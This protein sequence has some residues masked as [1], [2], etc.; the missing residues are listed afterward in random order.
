MKL[1]IDTNVLIDFLSVRHPFYEPAAE[2][3]TRAE[4][5]EVRC[6]LSALSVVTAQ[7]VCCERCKMPL[8]LWK[9]NMACLCNFVDVVDVTKEDILYSCLSDWA[10][11]EDG[12]Q[13]SCAMGAGCGAVVTR[14]VH[15]FGQAAV[16]VLTPDETVQMLADK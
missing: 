15:D 13:Y 12:V 4:R 1:F 6:V 2:L 3:F 14:N 16:P 8:A 10:D 11:F 7:Y 9:R 5:G